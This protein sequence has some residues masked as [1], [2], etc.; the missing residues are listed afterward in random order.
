MVGAAL[1]LVGEL[2]PGAAH[3]GAFGVAGLDHEVRDDAV[4]DGAV[5]EFVALFGAGVPF[6]GAFG[7][8]DEILDGLGGL[9]FEETGFEGTLR[10][11]E[12]CGGWHAFSLR[13]G[14]TGWLD[15]CRSGDA[16]E[17]V[18]KSS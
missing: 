7:E 18:G 8:A 5:V 9:L 14:A 17:F 1:G 11:L 4:K 2:V 15:A 10:G 13:C 16:L 3:A 6:L 12:D